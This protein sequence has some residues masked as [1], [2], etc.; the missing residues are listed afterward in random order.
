MTSPFLTSDAAPE[1]MPTSM[2]QEF[3][4]KTVNAS[5][6]PGLCGAKPMI[7]GKNGVPIITKR[8]SASVRQ[9]GGSTKGSRMET[10]TKSL[11]IFDL[12]IITE[13]SIE[14][15][16]SNAGRVFS[17]ITD[18]LASAMARGVDLAALH[19]IEASSGNKITLL[20]SDYV[21][22]TTNRLAV[23]FSAKNADQ[24]LWQGYEQLVEDGKKFNGL[25]LDPRYVAKIA[26]ARDNQGRRLNPEIDMG[27]KLS[28]YSGHPLVSDNVVSGSVDELA[29]TG[30]RG[31][32]G[33]WSALRW[34]YAEDVEIF[35]QTAGDPLG[36]G[37]LTARRM[38]AVHANVKVGLG[39]LDNQAF[40]AYE[41]PGIGG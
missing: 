9:E 40:I 5:I 39:I 8:P 3:W 31:F 30:V 21:N 20:G 34:G 26:N 10:A 6:L 29:D 4:N 17:E 7:I 19:G 12:Q 35:T 13:H 1:L 14:A 23:D 2:A 25:A 33:D 16:K 22:A 15:V 38:V 37:D 24:Y 18:E 41:L 27:A 36:N 32:G 11:K 28:S